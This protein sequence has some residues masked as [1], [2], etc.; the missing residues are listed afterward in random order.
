PVLSG[1]IAVFLFL[2][3]RTFVLRSADS[4]KRAVFLF[5]F[6]VTATIAVNVFFIVYKGAKGLGLDDT[7]LTTAFMWAFGL[8]IA[9][10]L[11]MIPTVLPYMRKNIAAKFNDD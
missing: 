4:Y 5:P 2:F 9:C 1:V 11:V 10:G 8:G 7:T 3:V 6:L